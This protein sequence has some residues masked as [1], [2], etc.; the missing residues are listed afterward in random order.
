MIRLLLLITSFFLGIFSLSAQE[1]RSFDGTE[2]NLLNTD[3]GATHTQLVRVVPYDYADGFSTPG[4]IDRPNARQISNTIFQQDSLIMDALALSDY[5][6]VWGQFL[7][8][9]I[10]A[11]GESHT[12][13]AMIPVPQ[14]DPWFDPFNEGDKLIPMFRSAPMAGTGTSPNNPREHANNITAFVD[15]SNVYGSDQE[16]ADWLRSNIDG[17]LLVSADNLLPFNT[18]NG[19]QFTAV[20]PNAPHMDNPTNFAFKFFVA[21]DSRANENPLLAAFHTIFVREHNRLCDEL[22]IANPSWNDELL[23]QQ[24]RRINSGL[25]QSVTYN[26]WLPAMGVHLD[27]FSGYDPIVNPTISNLFSGAAY[28]L[29]HTLISSTIRRMAYDG[30][31]S[32]EGDL[33]LADAFFNPFVILDTEFGIDPFLKGMGVQIQQ[34]LDVQ[35]VSDVRNFLFGPP[36]AGGLDLAAININRGRERGIP[37]FNT[38]RV[39]YGLPAY[40]SFSELTG[41]SAFA[42]KLELLYGTTDKIDAWVGFLAEWHMPNALFGPTLMAVMEQQFEDLRNGDRFFYLNDPDLTQEEKDMI[43]NTMLSDIIERNTGITVMQDDVFF[44]MPHDMLCQ[45]VVN[46]ATIQGGLDNVNAEG[47]SGVEVEFEE[48]GNPINATNQNVD[49]SFSFLDIETCA[50]YK[51]T[52]TKDGNYDNGVTTLD[53]VKIK[54]HILNITNFTEPMEFLAADANGSNSISA[55]DLVQLRK[56]ILDPNATFNGSPSWRFIPANLSF[57]EPTN[58]WLEPFNNF[59]E[60]EQ[61][62]DNLQTNFIGYKVGDVNFSANVNELL[63][64][65]DRKEDTFIVTTQNQTLK[66]GETVAVEFSADDLAKI[67]GYSFTLN[68]DQN[69]L[70]F[71]DLESQLANL[72]ADNFNIMTAVGAITT[73][74]LG[75]VEA[76]EAP[77]FTLYFEA[78]SNDLELK[79][80][81]HINSRYTKAEAVDLELNALNVA[82]HF[83]TETGTLAQ[84]DFVLYQNQPNPFQNETIIGFN[85]PEANQATFSVFDVTGKLLYQLNDEFAAG[86]NE[87]SLQANELAGN[88]VLYYE[89]AGN[90]GRVTKKLFLVK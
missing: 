65:D 35:V 11:V 39:A 41:N 44:A 75:H 18:T 74:W 90:F 33:S 26:Q 66:A 34:D 17:K 21:G 36:G 38:I 83:D 4:G 16:R 7:D 32:P 68:Y 20:D 48:L 42:D 84:N 58:P 64:A 54:K 15:A 8:H 78:K 63:A 46:E 62:I 27:D 85:L 28:R 71:I 50:G 81:I 2:N 31:E 47:I 23:Y 79:D 73:N 67:E 52:P 77:V 49:N 51:I 69:A 61:L 40:D 37:D 6:W 86:H 1:Y 70:E 80:L 76:S 13:P 24:A 3:W 30:T 82:L 43:H 25:I 87:I 60:V 88:G 45:A 12:E 53:M 59:V 19:Q 9:D 55:L 29:G 89:L 22:K 14:G 10:T 5:I 72:G 57:S 56:V